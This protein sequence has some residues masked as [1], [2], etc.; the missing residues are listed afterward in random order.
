MKT[1]KTKK[2]TK[3]KAT[4]KLPPK[5]QYV[6]D[7]YWRNIPLSVLAVVML[8]ILQGILIY[9]MFQAGYSRFIENIEAAHIANASYVLKHFGE[10]WNNQW[11][12]GFPTHLT[13]PP[14]MPYLTALVSFLT[15]LDISHVYRILT[16]IFIMFTPVSIYL[17][18]FYLTRR[19]TAAFLASLMYI[20]LPSVAYLFIPQIIGHTALTGYVPFRYIVFSQY[21]EGPHLSSLFFIPLAI[22]YFIKSYR[23]PDIKN[24]VIAASFIALTM[25][26][27]LF[28]GFALMML[29]F[30]ALTG[31][32][33]V[34][35]SNINIKRLIIIGMMA[36]GL[37]AFAYDFSF[38][39]SILDSG[40]IHPENAI[41]LPPFLIIFV[42]VI[43]GLLP[44]A[45]LIRGALMGNESKFKT[46]FLISWVILFLAIPV[47]YYH[48]GFSLVPQPNRYLPELQMG[49]TIFSA[50]IITKLFDHYKL[51]SSKINFV[52]KS[53]IIVLVFASL[54]Y[55]SSS[56][57]T[58]PYYL[59]T[60]NKMDYT[61]D[62]KIATWLDQNINQSTGERA[63]LTG[64]PAF[65]LTAFNDVPEIRGSADNAQP[66]PWW[67]DIAF[68]I[69]KGDNKEL[70][71]A[72]LQILNIKYILVNYPESGTH[73]IDY[74]NYDR[75]NDY[76]LVTEFADGGFKMFEVPD[77][78]L[79]LFNI[80]NKNN[81]FYVEKFNDKKDT[82]NIIKFAQMIRSSNSAN[83]EYKI[84]RPSEYE[85]TARD[86]NADDRLIFKMNYDQRWKAV[87]ENGK[88]LKID[89]VG[90]NMMMIT[91]NT[92][93]NIKFTMIVGS[94]WTEYVGLSITIVTVVIGGIWLIYR[95]RRFMD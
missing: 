11:Y 79:S 15:K 5:A 94:Y 32:I 58:K 18:A 91:P 51:T 37:T 35:V 67:A 82:E 26:T 22:L 2:I 69:N 62:Y 76:K 9:P 56:Y 84:I 85:I 72:W 33:L 86:L 41:H 17:L 13:Y 80:V 39:K 65:W 90:P 4:P 47:V 74:E 71:T 20:I 38:I 66:N 68:Q 46:Y 1:K 89:A 61:N 44:A 3:I 12:F 30:L 43:F 6:E 16:A 31:K 52:K 87:D 92:T 19:K 29:L 83:V 53:T 70:T 50:I 25:L 49:F 77:A 95:K 55:I 14:I 34:Y 42:A 48:F 81:E 73:Y 28:G 8:V 59:I 54:Y 78:N 63:Y 60:P 93:G 27:N 45:L 57:L 75:F 36:Y 64:T 21:G 10:N 24:Y 88:Q 40:Y 7:A 23:Q